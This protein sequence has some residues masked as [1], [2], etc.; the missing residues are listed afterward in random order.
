MPVLPK[1][2]ARR[3][4]KRKVVTSKRNILVK[5]LKTLSELKK[6]YKASTMPKTSKIKA[7]K[8]SSRL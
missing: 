4:K 8:K 7:S 3:E 5:I 6:T 1:T 2:T